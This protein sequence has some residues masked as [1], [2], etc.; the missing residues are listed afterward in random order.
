MRVALFLHLVGALVWIGG[1]FFAYF[2]LR[3][4]T[5]VLEPPQ[6]LVLWSE[7]LGRFFRWVWGSV[8]L[9]L[10]SGFYM[11]AAIAGVAKVPFNVH[12]MLYLGLF[13]VFI[14]LYVV[15]V[16]FSALKRAIATEDWSTGSAALSSIRTAVA[17]N[18]VLGLIIMGVA[19]V[20]RM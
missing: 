17:V 1:M 10:G 14:F 20:G 3:P 18:L 12:I 6:R 5:M 15:V 9:I 11:L 2:T 4:S 19:T 8:A 13:M 7:I 16:P